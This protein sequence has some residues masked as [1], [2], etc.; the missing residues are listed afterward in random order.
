MTSNNNLWH[1]SPVCGRKGSLAG[2]AWACL[3]TGAAG[4]RVRRV[5]SKSHGVQWPPP[6][7]AVSQEDALQCVTAHVLVLRWLG[8]TQ[9]HVQSQYRR[10]CP[11]QIVGRVTHQDHYRHSASHSL[12]Q[13][14]PEHGQLAQG[15]AESH[16]NL[17][18]CAALACF[19]RRL[20][21]SVWTTPRRGLD[22]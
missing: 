18:P 7:A 21:W 13:N 5:A 20:L 3:H 16:S 19:C 8:Q 9:G 17:S 22:P 6:A 10:G 15:S 2:L 1:S 11:A 12:A 14:S 4:P